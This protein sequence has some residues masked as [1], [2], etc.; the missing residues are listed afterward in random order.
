MAHNIAA[1]PG[2]VVMSAITMLTNPRPVD[3]VRGTRNVLFDA[4]IY[5]NDEH[6]QTTLG[7]L[8]YFISDSMTNYPFATDDFT[9]AFVIA[10]ISTISETFPENLI[11]SGDGELKV[12]DYAFMGDIID[13]TVAHNDISKKKLP[14]ITMTGFVKQCDMRAHSFIVAA[15]QYNAILH[16]LAPLTLEC[17]IPE[18]SK[19]WPSNKKPKP[20]VNSAVSVAGFLHHIKRTPAKSIIAFE[21]ELT[22]LAYI[23]RSAGIDT[24]HTD[25]STS[26]T[27]P[28]T[29]FNYDDA[30]TQAT[31]SEHITPPVLTTTQSTSL[32]VDNKHH[33]DED[34]PADDD[35]Q[36]DKP[37]ASKKKKL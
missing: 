7:V 13:L 1:P 20:T 11:S 2:M 35:E 32:H 37:S 18:D 21:L 9:P 30:T 14:V 12:S 15:S 28:H 3:A 16:T 24:N 22:S 25:T 31:D 23:N 4:N 8:R 36:D 5:V 10:T 33:R 27:R 17:Y 19:R 34:N 6:R 26:I 29:L